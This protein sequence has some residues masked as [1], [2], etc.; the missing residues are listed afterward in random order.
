MKFLGSLVAIVLLAVVSTAFAEPVTL[1]N[2]EATRLF[3]ALRT[4]QAGTTA[5]NTRNGA[6]NINVLRPVVEAYELGQGVI[7]RKGSAIAPNDP[8]RIHKLD[9]LT[10]EAQHLA[11][12][13]NTVNLTLFA[14]SDDEVRDAKVPMDSLSEFLHFLTPPAAPPPKK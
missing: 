11:K 5:L 6:L 8:E 14:L 1:S 2:A 4:T 9:A 10:E 7:A 3:A 13:S 12:A